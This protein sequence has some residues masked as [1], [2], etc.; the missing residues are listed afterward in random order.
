MHKLKEINITVTLYAKLQREA[1]MKLYVSSSH[2][3][4]A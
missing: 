3:M 2:E 1:D 4:Q